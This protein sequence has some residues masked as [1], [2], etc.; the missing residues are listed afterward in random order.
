LCIFEDILGTVDFV[1]EYDGSVVFRTCDR[2]KN[3]VVFQVGTNDAD[4]AVAVGKL[5]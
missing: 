3:H 5:V 2:E 1:D 4:K